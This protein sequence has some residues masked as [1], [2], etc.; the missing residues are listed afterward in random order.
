MYQVKIN[1]KT[2]NLP[3]NVDELTLG[4]FLALR[5]V[6]DKN[7]MNRIC[8]LLSA[9][10]DEFLSMPNNK[11]INK[12]VE[13]VIALAQILNADMTAFFN[14]G[15][16]IE[17]PQT[18]TILGKEIKIPGDIET[19][20]YWASRIVK[21]IMLDQINKTG[22]GANFDPTDVIDQVLAH[23]LY[24]PYTEMKYNEMQAERFR[25][26]VKEM[27]LKPAV[28]VA[29]FFFLKSKSLYLTKID[30]W[31]TSLI[32]WKLKRASQRLKNTKI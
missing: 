11:S 24:C 30:R 14:G 31:I 1:G 32:I 4:Q 7:T 26:I 28:Q 15:E 6:D 2:Y 5:K 9:D 21:G 25:E 22:T 10:E 17:L 29:N 13:N 19:Q 12:E 23:Y 16:K 20:P 18:V 8:I 3:S 27:P